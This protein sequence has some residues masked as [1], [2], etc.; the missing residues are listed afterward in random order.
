MLIAI[1]KI[2]DT[3]L[4]KYLSL[5]TRYTNV[6]LYIQ[7]IKTK[8]HHCVQVARVP[9]SVSSPQI[10]Q[11]HQSHHRLLVI[12]CKL[13]TGRAPTRTRSVE[14]IKAPKNSATDPIIIRLIEKRFDNHNN[15]TII[16]S[17]QHPINIHRY[18][19]HNLSRFLTSVT[20][21]TTITIA[22]LIE[23]AQVTHRNQTLDQ[24]PPLAIPIAVISIAPVLDRLI[25]HVQG[26]ATTV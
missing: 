7:L 3:R 18:H 14:I 13:P 26:P 20:I 23:T 17:I 15:I 10:D 6:F 22:L 2:K 1:D 12:I 25:F 19:L 5:L 11:P 24:H 21:I 16:T 4:F 8:A 9:F